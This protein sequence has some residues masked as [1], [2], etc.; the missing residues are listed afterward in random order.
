MPTSFAS[1]NTSSP[2]EPSKDS[3]NI[4]DDGLHEISGEY[5]LVISLTRVRAR[6]GHEARVELWTAYTP[7]H[8]EE[9]KCYVGMPWHRFFFF[10]RGGGDWSNPGNHAIG[11]DLRRSIAL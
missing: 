10:F 2:I 5:M 1:G 3:A 11:T 6:A 4:D 9:R 8:T 7:F